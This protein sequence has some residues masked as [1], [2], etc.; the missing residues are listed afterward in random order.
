MKKIIKLNDSLFKRTENFL[1]T[2]LNNKNYYL[3]E[4]G[5]GFNPVNRF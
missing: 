5:T 3:L 4:F 2:Y 1:H